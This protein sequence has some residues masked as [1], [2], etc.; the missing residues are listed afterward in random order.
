MS[1][2][3]KYAKRLNIFLLLNDE[4]S[5]SYLEKLLKEFCSEGVCTYKMHRSNIIRRLLY[6]ECSSNSISL[7]KLYESIENMILGK[8]SE[9]VTWHKIEIIE[10][11]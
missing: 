9:I 1:V 7:D 2:T 3:F 5:I 4:N 8:L 11:R 10:V 6:I